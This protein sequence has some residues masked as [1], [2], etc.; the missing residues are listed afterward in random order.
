MGTAQK[1]GSH[2]D[3]MI[4]SRAEAKKIG[5]CNGFPAVTCA[6]LSKKSDFFD[7]PRNY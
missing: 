2:M 5:N 3:D 7:S 4:I 1:V 6:G